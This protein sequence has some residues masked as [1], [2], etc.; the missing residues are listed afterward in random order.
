MKKI[1]SYLIALALTAFTFA[2]CEDVPAPF[3]QP[4]NPVEEIAVDPE[5]SGTQADPYNVAAII[6][7]TSGLDADTPSKEVYFKG[8]IS[9]IKDVDTS[10]SYGNATYYITDDKD[11]K[12]SQFYIYR[13]YGLGGQKFN[14]P[15]ATII[16]V[17]DEVLLKSKVT[18]YKGTTPETVQNECIIVELN[19]KKADGSG[20]G[21]DEDGVAKGTG[22]A[23]DPFNVAAAIAKCKEVGTTASTE[24]YY[25]KGIVVKGG[26]AS[27][28]FGNVTFDMGDTKESTNLFRAYQVAG[29]NGA[30]LAD[31]YEV[32]AGDEVVVYGPVVTFNTT[33][34]TAG[35]SAAQI[36]TI[37]GKA[38]E[39][40]GSGSGGSGEGDGTEAKPYNVTAAIAAGSGTNVFIKAYIVGWIDGQSLSSTSAKF[41]G[42][43]TIATNVLIA[44]TADETD[45]KKCMPVQLPS[46]AI[47][48]AVN[49]Q[50]NPG[51]YKKEIILVGNIE[52][53]FGAT[54][55]KSTSYA[56]IGDTEAGTKPAGGNPPTSINKGTAEAP[57]TVAQA[58]ALIDSQDGTISDA[59][60]KGIISQIDSYDS[61]YKS[62]TYWISDD[63]NKT[64]QLKVY[65]GKGLNGADFTAKDN[66]TLG[67]KVVI[68][69]SLKKY[70]STYEFDKTSSILSIE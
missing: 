51:N 58:I 20:E 4:I 55:V 15:N 18:N 68:K 7:F 34:E 5:G 66:L 30:A 21:G 44:N 33:Y 11:G 22:T 36:V 49:L 9:Q 14:E 42:T 63:G 2:S 35:K 48:T 56:K 16:K 26:T 12:G 45:Y 10:G 43:A 17:G 23:S 60:V 19:G 64:T 67:K 1:S 37:N 24:K 39:E 65:S 38:T 41:N 3:G 69:G 50:N 61:K 46:G 29:T 6:A 52:K 47:R 28:G 32:K 40:G 25:I 27:G 57:L 70:N 8:F 54:G 31:G 62:I 53:Y 59:Y 13:G